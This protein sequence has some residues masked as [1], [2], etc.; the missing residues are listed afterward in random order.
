M[1]GEELETAV[2]RLSPAAGFTAA[3][4]WRSHMSPKPVPHVTARLKRCVTHIQ[5]HIEVLSKNKSLSL[6]RIVGSGLLC[7]T[8]K[9]RML[10]IG[11]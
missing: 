3:A 4:I 1:R 11:G 6:L 10:L 9:I 8:I 7:E 5:K 2:R